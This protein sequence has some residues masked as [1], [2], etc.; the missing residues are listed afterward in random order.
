MKD[1]ARDL[2]VRTDVPFKDL[3]E[4]KREIIFHGPAVKRHIVYQNQTS[5]A[6][7]EMDLTISMQ[8]T[9]WKMH[10]PR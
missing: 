9:P 1:I 6:A 2:G 3:T 10:S 7:G 5:G 4:K 8:A